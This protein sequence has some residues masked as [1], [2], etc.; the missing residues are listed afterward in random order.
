[1]SEYIKREDVL[2]C[3]KEASEQIDW[4]QSGDGDAFKHY[5]GAVYRTIASS[6]CVPSADVV[7]RKELEVL[8]RRLAMHEKAMAK[9]FAEQTEPTTQTETQN[10]NLTFEKDECAKEYEELGLKEL[11]ELINADRKTKNCSEIPNSSKER[12][13]E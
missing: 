2:K 11:K 6:D 9:V 3:L 8:E 4:G 13:R 10:S 5:I 1:M 7:E 12:S